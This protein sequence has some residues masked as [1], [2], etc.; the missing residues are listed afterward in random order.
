MLS[1]RRR[2]IERYLAFAP[3]E[4]GEMS[5]RQG[6]PK[7]AV[8]IDVSAARSVAVYRSFGLV[9]WNFKNFCQ[10]CRRW[11]VAGTH[12]DDRAGE[13]EHGA[14]DGAVH[15]AKPDA[16][17]TCDDPLV[18]CRIDR[19]VWLDVFVALAVAIGIEDERSPTLRLLL[20]ARL[21]VH[22]GVDPAQ[23]AAGRAA[24]AQPQRVV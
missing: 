22:L 7:N 21:V 10:G 12:A 19:L 15:R 4:A 9:P 20:V 1:G 3:V 13:A 14:P 8:S 2:T 6:G 16:V 23:D 18:F 11:I 24:A 5:T 17:V